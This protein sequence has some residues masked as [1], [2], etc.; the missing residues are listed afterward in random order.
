MVQPL[1]LEERARR[2]ARARPG[3]HAPEARPRMPEDVLRSSA[4]HLR[5][6][7]AGP[8]PE[9]LGRPEACRTNAAALVDR[10][11]RWPTEATPTSEARPAQ[12]DPARAL[13][14]TRA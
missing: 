1:V 10:R 14:P 7:R 12:S 4:H 8:P 3:G 2:P 5:E 9:I 6:Y 11:Q 13:T